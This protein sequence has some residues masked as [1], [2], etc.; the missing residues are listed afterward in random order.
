MP[1]GYKLE[2]SGMDLQIELEPE[3]HG[4][5]VRRLALLQAI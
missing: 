5:T 3:Q 1:L 4:A 2:A